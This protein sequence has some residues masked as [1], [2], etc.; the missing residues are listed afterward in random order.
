MFTLVI[1]V[2]SAG[3][4]SDPRTVTYIPNF[5]TEALCVQAGEQVLK[6]NHGTFSGTSTKYSCV[7][8]S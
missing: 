8:A 1:T 5:K 2:V 4:F 7:K 6:Q 3:L